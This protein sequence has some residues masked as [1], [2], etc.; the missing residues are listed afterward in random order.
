M[1]AR[2]GALLGLVGF[3]HAAVQAPAGVLDASTES[4]TPVSPMVKL[5]VNGLP[6]DMA[7]CILQMHKSPG[8]YHKAGKILGV[9]DEQAF[10]KHERVSLWRQMVGRRM[11]S[12][13]N[14]EGTHD[15]VYYIVPKV[16]HTTIVGHLLGSGPFEGSSA[17]WDSAYHD[18]LNTTSLLAEGGKSRRVVSGLEQSRPYEW[19]VVRDPLEHFMAGF[20]QVEFN[21]GA[22]GW[23]KR[24]Q[25]GGQAEGSAWIA[26]Y[27]AGASTIDRATAMLSDFLAVRG[28]DEY[29]SSLC[30]ITPQTLGYT[31]ENALLA[32]VG[33]GFLRLNYVGHIEDFNRAWLDV[34]KGL[35]VANPQPVSDHVNA[36]KARRAA[37]SEEIREDVGLLLGDTPGGAGNRTAFVELSLF[38]ADAKASASPL[39]QALCEMFEREC[40]CLGYTLPKHCQP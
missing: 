16:A 31:R 9:P 27:L 25:D 11:N 21:L 18:E 36:Q 23:A 17:N 7:A 3:V 30:H 14:A 33:S 1:G 29:L 2:R 32:P 15:M 4:D 40:T 6:D 37:A 38:F 39:S 28:P 12:S 13:T 34:Q 22:S 20:D 26:R 19:T 24:T 5:G 35:G 10:K 8:A